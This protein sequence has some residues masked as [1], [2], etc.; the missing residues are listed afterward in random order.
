MGGDESALPT[1]KPGMYTEHRDIEINY[2]EAIDQREL[3]S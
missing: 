3:Y 2:G 1:N